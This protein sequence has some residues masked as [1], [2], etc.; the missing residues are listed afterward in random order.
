[1]G[2]RVAI[3][4]LNSLAVTMVASDTPLVKAGSGLATFGV[5]DGPGVPQGVAENHQHC[6]TMILMR[7]KQAIR[8]DRQYHCL[9]I[10][11]VRT[12]GR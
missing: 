6:R 12:C 7:F 9:A 3:V 2:I 11:A 1:M 10:I 8:R 4:S 5:P